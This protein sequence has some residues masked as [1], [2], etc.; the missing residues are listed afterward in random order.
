MFFMDGCL[1]ASVVCVVLFSIIGA[2]SKPGA[3]IIL[4]TMYRTEE[5]GIVFSTLIFLSRKRPPKPSPSDKSTELTNP[6]T[7]E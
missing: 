3:Y 6:S 5:F 2:G 4:H 7:V 1:V